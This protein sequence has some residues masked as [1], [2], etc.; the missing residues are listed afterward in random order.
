MINTPYRQWKNHR[1]LMESYASKLLIALNDVDSARYCARLYAI[2]LDDFQNM[3]S[4]ASVDQV[5]LIS[6]QLKEFNKAKHPINSTGF[7]LVSL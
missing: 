4:N 7:Q 1:K 2:G 6:K 3:F 5:L